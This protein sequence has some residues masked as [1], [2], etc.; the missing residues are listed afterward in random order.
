MRSRLLPAPPFLPRFCPG[1][2]QVLPRFPPPVWAV[3]ARHPCP[4]GLPDKPRFHHP[5]C[6]PVSHPGFASRF[7]PMGRA[8]VHTQHQLSPPHKRS[9]FPLRLVRCG[10]A[11]APCRRGVSFSGTDVTA[12]DRC[13]SM[14]AKRRPPGKRRDSAPVRGWS[15]IWGKKRK[16]GGR[17]GSQKKHPGQAGNRDVWGARTAPF[18]CSRP[19]VWPKSREM[20][21]EQTSSCWA[22]ISIP[23]RRGDSAT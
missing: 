8:P 17:C 1:S 18:L 2:A 19:F 4:S 9:P 3:P 12:A 14:Q 20:T 16:R 5:V 10:P 22:G 7:A 23:V 21:Y 6:L 15:R 13:G 11:A